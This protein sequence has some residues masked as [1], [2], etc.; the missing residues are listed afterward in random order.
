MIL[1][2]HYVLD[3]S[4][5]QH[6]ETVVNR[7]GRGLS[8]DDLRRQFHCFLPL[9]MYASVEFFLQMSLSVHSQTNQYLSR[10]LHCLPEVGDRDS[11]GAI[12]VNVPK[13]IPKAQLAF[14]KIVL[15]K[16]EDHVSSM[17]NTYRARERR[18]C[19]ALIILLH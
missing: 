16:K 15:W 11:H 4:H 8:W 9:E 10:N 18:K 3:V 5:D 2:I 17:I 19:S 12:F 6:Q 7:P 13:E 14:I 1:L